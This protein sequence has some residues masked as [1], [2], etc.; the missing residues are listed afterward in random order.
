MSHRTRGG[1]SLSARL[2][3]LVATLL[4]LSVPA[5][6]TAAVELRT[7]VAEPVTA[8][9]PCTAE[10]R[11]AIYANTA[12]NPAVATDFFN[13]QNLPA[14]E[15]L[16]PDRRAGASTDFCV[17][18]TLTPDFT[19][20]NRF[21]YDPSPS[22]PLDVATDKVTGDDMEDIAV[23]LPAGY[24]AQLASVPACTNAQFGHDAATVAENAPDPG[25]ITW[26][27]DVGPATCAAASQVGEA[28]IRVS[29]NLLDVHTIIATGRKPATGPCGRS[30]CTVR[31]WIYKL[32]SGPN[33][34]GRLG[35]QVT[36]PIGADYPSKFIVRLTLAPDGSGR[37]VA[38]ALN[39][40][41]YVVYSDALLDI[42]VETVAMRMWGAQ[43]D[44]P[45]LPADFSQNATSCA[46]PGTAN[47]DVATH[48]GP[49]VFDPDTYA[50][51]PDPDTYVPTRSSL[52]APGFTLTGCDTLPFS[53]AVDVTTT[54]RRPGVPTGVEVNVRLGQSASGPGTALLKD[55]EVTLPEGL[56]L[57]AQVGTSASGLR[58]CSAAQFAAA[59]P[60]TTN[61]CPAETRVGSVHIVSPLID[62][63]LDGSVYLGEQR[64]V[65]ELPALYLEASFAGSTAPDA[66]RIKLVGQVRADADGRLTTTFRDN[67]QLRFSLLRLTFDGGAHALFTTPTTCGDHR[68]TSRMTP[69]SAQPATEVTTT[70]TIDQDC[71][72]PFAPTVK[73]EA[74]DPV[75][76]GRSAT[77]ITI[78]RPDRAAWLT[79]ATVSLPGG[80]LADLN[81]AAECAPAAAAAAACPEASRIASVTTIA[82]AGTD[83]LE[84]RGAM[85]L[86]ERQD[87]D[88]AGASIVVRAKIGDLDLGNVVV[89]G[90]IKLRATD[91][92]LDFRT[93]IPTRHRGVALQLRKVVVDLDR[94]DFP[95]NPT[96]CGPL[97]YSAA[98]TGTGTASATPTGTLAYT[99]CAGLPF[100][101]SLK[102]TLTGEN[103]PGGFPG[104]YVRL[105]SPEGD[106]GMRSASVTLPAGV[107]A[108]LPNVK[109]PCPREDFDAQRCAPASRVGSAVARVSI[110]P[111][112]IRGDIFLIKVPGKT[113]PG[114]GLN[115]TGR[116]AQR[117]TS[118]VEVN[119]D[120]RLVTN[121]PAIPDLP[122][123]SLE[124]QVDSGPKSP[125]QLPE[126][127]CAGG[128]NWDGT[129]V[130]QGGQTASAKTG[131]QCAASPDARLSDKRGLSVRLFDFGGR[132]LDYAKATLPAGWRF[133]RKAAK[134]KGALWVRM[135]GATPKLRLTSRSLTAFSQ[136]KVATDLR[137]K[138][139]G[140]VVR[141]T[142]PA[143]RKVK[144]LSIPLRLAFTDGTVQ[145]QVLTVATR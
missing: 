130:G 96:S 140:R 129:F 136:S 1:A 111:D 52:T 65:G 92:G 11:N 132:K 35:V 74:T 142:T 56:E 112:A 104:M 39:A 15:N 133:D 81:R 114:L 87:G 58:L 26:P 85:Y 135:T 48:G 71:D 113:L 13:G 29:T 90:R 97:P 6:A 49:P 40:P 105:D 21:A 20:L 12:F 143:A 44:H 34:L 16:V 69:W 80:F 24:A 98:I 88:V 94:K 134:T 121:F 18:F 138:I 63:T 25:A 127:A 17:G 101:P 61:A 46:A 30:I 93:E 54:E 36:P 43:A 110:T 64:E 145:T 106:V 82:G 32:E 118:T 57:G 73:V 99:G 131:L 125:L 77:R 137:V 109:N 47:I 91:A 45:T 7:A 126:G 3:V 5:T 116:Y 50:S 33:E 124:I 76:G 83:P 31:S 120:G 103:R 144:S 102:A 89:P 38:T 2:F 86:T 100:R 22:D 60:L 27:A 117:V 119:K 42:Y 79:G 41:R 141:P 70:L 72:V 107:A 37:V 51:L 53:P 122:L 23:T 128:S 62:R 67:P 14:R 139:G 59:Q 78:E 95:V 75:A 55:A 66:P 84:L 10:P 68:A 28:A 123:R 19:P 8:T 9:S 115:F 4:G 108:A